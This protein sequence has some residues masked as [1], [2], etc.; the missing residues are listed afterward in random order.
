MSKKRIAIL[1]STGSIGRQCLE[2]IANHSDRFDAKILTARD[3]PETLINQAIKYHP[4]AV[5]I[6][7]P[8]HYRRVSEALTPRSIKVFG[9]NESLCDVVS[10]ENIDLV[11]NA[12]VGFSGLAPTLTALKSRKPV[13]IANKESLVA[14]GC[15]VTEAASAHKT[16]IIPVDS[17]HSAIFQ[18]LM[19]ETSS[20]EKLILTASGGPFFN[21]PAQDLPNI[22]KEQA[23]NHPSWVMGKKVT[24]DSA[25]MMNKGLEV[26]E[27]HHLFGVPS[28]KIEI[29]IHPQSIVHSMV[30]FE[31]G[32]VKAHLSHPDM[33]IP[34]QYAL[35]FPHRLPHHVSRLSFEALGHLDFYPLELEKFPSLVL[36]IHALEQ[37]GNMP[38]ALSAA[39]EIA[40][41]AFL[42]ERISFHHI[43]KVIEQTIQSIFF[44]P[45]PSLSDIIATD[46]QSRYLAQNL[47][48]TF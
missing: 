40:V 27:A 47:L 38:C 48:T 23:L 37:G 16:P 30:Q 22:R 20:I 15:L 11:L 39:N 18:C 19:G 32:S 6:A 34:I 29:I 28:S 43:P 41:T 1:G 17:E 10:F 42:D 14:G 35:T 4:S 45:K 46:S 13:A 44:I 36:A 33:R 2:V 24:I 21:T 31:D 5:V 25:T 9:G 12:L 3:N 7:N 26:I 8:D